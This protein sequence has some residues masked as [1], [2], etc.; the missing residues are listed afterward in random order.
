MVN[1]LIYIF[2]SCISIFELKT[3]A[4]LWTIL[5]YALLGFF[6]GREHRSV[7]LLQYAIVY[8]VLISKVWK[9]KRRQFSQNCFKFSCQRSLTGTFGIK[10]L[11]K[12]PSERLCQFCSHSVTTFWFLGCWKGVDFLFVHGLI[13][14]LLNHRLDGQ[15]VY[16]RVLM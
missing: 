9:V 8:C 5:P 10:M 12:D 1:W 11:G 15:Y 4:L 16:W 6:P 2:Y 7:L 3:C 14:I 13:I